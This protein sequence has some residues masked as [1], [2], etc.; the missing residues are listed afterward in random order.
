[1]PATTYPLGAEQAGYYSTAPLEKTLSELVDFDLVNQLPAAADRRCRAC[2]H[3]SDALFRQP[4]RRT[5]RQAYHGVGRIAAGISG[6]A[7]RR[8]ALLGRRHSVQHADGGRVRRQPA[9]ELADL[10]RASV[11]SDRRRA[12]HD[13]GGAQP[14]KG[15]AIFQPGRQ[16]YRA[17]AADA[18]PAS[19]HQ[20]SSP[21]ACR[22]SSATAPRCASLP[23]YGCLTRMH[24]VRLLAPQL[25]PRRSHQGY[26][27]QPV[28]HSQRWEAG[29][30]HTKAVLERKPWIG[31]FDPLSGVVLHEQMEVMAEAAE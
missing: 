9:Q 22:R 28:R 30:R 14:P 5:R 23:S 2:P 21:R 4:R 1:M 3:Q 10:R 12:D 18:S 29:Y 31:E 15:R 6:R 24:V 19:C 11:E 25:D 8:R 7:H 20:P 13:G 16:P 27:F 17:P 26:R